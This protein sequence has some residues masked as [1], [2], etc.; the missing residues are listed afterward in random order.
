MSIRGRFWEYCGRVTAGVVRPTQVAN[1]CRSRLA[2]K[3]EV[4]A[5]KPTHLSIFV[6]SRCNFR[7]DMCPTR[8]AKTPE[9]YEYRHRDAPDMSLEL[10]RIVLNRYPDSIR[11]ELI[12]VG[13]P[14]LNPR[15]F[16]LAAEC[17]KHRMIVNTVTNGLVL[18][19]HIPEIVRSG[20]EWICVSANGHTAKEFH[21][22]TGMPE[23]CFSRIVANADAL[24]RA[25]GKKAR[26]KVDLSF[27]I[28]RF[29][30]THIEEMIQLAQGVGA[31]SVY[32]AQFQPSPYPGFTPEERCLYADD[33]NAQAELARLMSGNYRCAVT[34]PRLL[35]RPGGKRTVCRWPFSLL[36][37][38]GAGFVGGCPMQLPNMHAN[39]TIYDQDPW[40]N[41]YFK[42]LR[43]RHLQGDLYWPCIF[44]IESGG[45]DPRRALR[46]SHSRSRS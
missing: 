35:Q 18:D 24:V 4:V 7:C 16:E 25:R 28:D 43:R 3:T 19:A 12:G 2:P 40:N 41:P 27:I 33:R 6:T 23:A 22:M 46:N 31:D 37:V 45:T 30:Y 21:R 29:N 10:L 13:E 36:Q 44:C 9:T 32:L 38:N 15:L 20:I 14:L 5:A 11:A 26:P 17:V 39:G 34:W 42:D 1:F 8:S